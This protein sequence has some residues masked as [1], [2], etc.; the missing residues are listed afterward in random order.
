MAQSYRPD[1]V[2]INLVGHGDLRSL[3]QE[4]LILTESTAGEFARNAGVSKNYVYQVLDP[5]IELTPSRGIARKLATAITRR[6]DLDRDDILS[7]VGYA[8]PAD[9]HPDNYGPG[10]VGR[11]IATLRQ[12]TER[13]RHDFGAGIGMSRKAITEAELGDRTPRPSMPRRLYDHYV[14]GIIP[15]GVPEQFRVTALLERFYPLGITDDDVARQPTLGAAMGTARRRLHVS[16]KETADRTGISVDHLYDVENDTY[17]PNRRT[18]RQLADLLEPAF[19]TQFTTDDLLERHGL[20]SRRTI[21]PRNFGSDQQRLW[22]TG[23]RNFHGLSQEEFGHELNVN[24]S[25]LSAYE[26]GRFSFRFEL[27]ER[28]YDQFVAPLH[29]PGDPRY[30]SKN[31][32]R[33]RFEPSRAGTAL[34]ALIGERDSAITEYLDGQVPLGSSSDADAMFSFFTDA[35]G[36]LRDDVGSEPTAAE[37]ADSIRGYY[38]AATEL[39]VA[40]RR[41]GTVEGGPPYWMPAHT[42]GQ[43]PRDRTSRTRSVKP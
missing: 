19:G 6:T 11:W 14:P 40:R 33:M 34:I 5:Q 28:A 25:T 20:E 10:D 2:T 13:N 37:V 15:Q 36:V 43:R 30:F 35:S 32:L 3:I 4:F 27:A 29:A 8:V 38:R 18:A 24:R 23:V 42:F 22:L 9:L 12:I 16:G 21:H 1:M 26:D 39:S 31:Y 41:I 7:H 17:P